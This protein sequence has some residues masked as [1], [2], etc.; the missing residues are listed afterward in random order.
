MSQPIPGINSWITRAEADAY[1]ADK[2]GA[3]AIWTALLQAT[4][5]QLIISACEWLMSAPGYSLSLTMTPTRKIKVAQCEAAWF[6]YR[7]NEEQERRR[8]LYAQGVRSFR[9]S[10]FSE[11]LEKQELPA[12]IAAL[13]EGTETG[14]GLMVKVSR[15]E[16]VNGG[17]ERAQR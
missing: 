17:D 2:Y 11:T 5:D 9:V 7:F 10:E 3:S 16:E 6:L 15:E 14:G 4:R 8:G 12:N 1:F 13:L